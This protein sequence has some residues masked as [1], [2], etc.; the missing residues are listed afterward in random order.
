MTARQRT[1]AAFLILIGLSALILLLIILIPPAGVALAIVLTPI[2]EVVGSIALIAIS[3]AV[4]FLALSAAAILL[5]AANK[6][7]SF[8]QELSFIFLGLQSMFSRSPAASTEVSL[9]VPAAAPPA[10][11]VVAAAPVP[12]V[13]PPPATPAAALTPPAGGAGASRHP[14]AAAGGGSSSESSLRVTPVPTR[15]VDEA[16]RLL[17]LR[18]IANSMTH[19]HTEEQISASE[20][21]SPEGIEK[22]AAFY[23]ETTTANPAGALGDFNRNCSIEGYFRHPIDGDPGATTYKNDMKQVISALT[24]EALDAEGNIPK[25]SIS[26]LIYRISGQNFLTPLIYEFSNVIPSISLG[27]YL[28]SGSNDTMNWGKDEDGIYIDLRLD[29]RK[30]TCSTTFDSIVCDL[31]TGD[32]LQ[33]SQD[34]EGANELREELGNLNSKEFGYLISASSR[35]RFRNEGGWIRPY[36]EKYEVTNYFPSEFPFAPGITVAPT[37]P[38]TAGTAPGGP[39]WTATTRPTREASEGSTLDSTSEED[40]MSG[41]TPHHT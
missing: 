34:D 40:R 11:D 1:I 22:Y 27:N 37:V 31:G 8:L 35:I 33:V 29:I 4:A 28:M 38:A 16:T 10:T 7:R 21:L 5:R 39:L 32:L 6:G 20:Y 23:T 26:E 30:L 3:A 14:P 41:T 12:V 24:G 18:L 25:D 19:T 36:C 2:I 17:E 9:A 13:A 15:V